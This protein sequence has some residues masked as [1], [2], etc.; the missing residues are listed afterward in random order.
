[1]RIEIKRDALLII[2]E[3]E[4][5][6]AFIEDTLHLKAAGDALAFER[7]NDVALGYQKTDAYVLKGVATKREIK[8]TTT[9]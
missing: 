3:D 8:N 4:L 7:V 9:P 6:R 2:P 1:M 5:D